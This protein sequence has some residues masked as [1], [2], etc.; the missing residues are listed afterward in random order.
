MSYIFISELR[1]LFC[2]TLKQM[3]RDN[4]EETK[5]SDRWVGSKKG[6]EGVRRSSA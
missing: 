5:V 3:L 6:L 1:I 2:A 4:A